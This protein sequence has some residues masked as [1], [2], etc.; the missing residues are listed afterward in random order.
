MQEGQWS[1]QAV[2]RW[3]SASVC[4]YLGVKLKLDVLL[5]RV[6]LPFQLE[7]EVRHACCVLAGSFPLGSRPRLVL[8]SLGAFHWQAGPSSC[9]MSAATHSCF[10]R[11]TWAEVS[12]GRQGPGK[13]RPWFRA[14]SRL[15]ITQMASAAGSSCISPPYT[16][17]DRTCL[18]VCVC[19]FKHR[20]LIDLFSSCLPT[21]SYNKVSLL[22]SWHPR[23]GI[24]MHAGWAS[25]T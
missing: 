1:L 4:Y 2:R 25:W 10:P 7:L 14:T 24:Q 6:S 9:T 11:A 20:L 15:V 8:G 19:I 12:S 3:V 16:S 23:L 22:S 21:S 18:C 17:T 13:T 5:L